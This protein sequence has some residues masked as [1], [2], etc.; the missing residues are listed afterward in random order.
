M[1]LEFL[2][3][4]IFLW[5]LLSSGFTFTQELCSGILGQ[6]IFEDG[7]FGSGQENIPLKDPQVAPGYIYTRNAPPPDGSYTL[8]NDMRRWGNNYGTWISIPDNSSDPNGYMM[9]VNAS[10]QPGVFYEDTITGLC[11]NTLYEFSAD[12]INIV[13]RSTVGHILPEVDFLIDGEVKYSTG[14]IPQDEQWKKYGFTFTLPVDK[15]SIKLTLIN[16]APGGTGNDLALD[17]ISFQPC[18][19]EG[20]IEIQN[21]PPLIFCEGRLDPL[22]LKAIV[23]TSQNVVQWQKASNQTNEWE[24]VGDENSLEFFHK[25]FTPGQYTYRFIAA[26]TGANL[27]NEKCR[28]ISEEVYL[29]VVPLHYEEVDTFCSG[30]EYMFNNRTLISPGIYI[31]TFT[32]HLGCDSIVQLELTEVENRNIEA[33]IA[34]TDPSCYNFEDGSIEVESIAGGYPP[35]SF[36]L[37]TES[38]NFS[39]IFNS[40]PAGEYNVYYEDRFGCNDSEPLTLINPE[41]LIVKTSGDT[42][43]DLGEEINVMATVN[44]DIKSLHWEPPEQVACKDC[45]T[46]QILPLNS[47]EFIVT[48]E[49]TNGCIAEDR[50]TIS[51]NKE[52]LPIA[53]PNAFSPNHDGVNDS[54]TVIAPKN[55]VNSIES[56]SVFDKWGNELFHA[57]NITGGGSENGWNGSANGQPAPYGV[58]LYQCSLRL[59]DGQI[60]QYSGDVL[61]IR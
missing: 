28:T 39:G 43:L 20:I 7:D 55:L 24:D 26:G 51:V 37:N 23:D 27:S 56:F 15:T 38:K 33:E 17:N 22:P 35:Y 52:N 9:V 16:R 61:L 4:I 59:L 29:E 58:Y 8:T 21:E 5:I 12:V 49:N 53:F 45:E 54:F 48:V 34:F 6:N 25:E 19:P 30:T 46:T 13:S 18:G 1:R 40:L 14:K 50:F 41:E 32:S 42:I 44:Q 36:S 10:Y 3:G 11:S 47:T 60:Y 57:G 2:W 31:D